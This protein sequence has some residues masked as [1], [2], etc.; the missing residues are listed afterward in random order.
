VLRAL[1]AGLPVVVVNKVDRPDARV[2]RSWT[3]L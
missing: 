1:Q 2:Q 3:G